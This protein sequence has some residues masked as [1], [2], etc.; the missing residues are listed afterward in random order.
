MYEEQVLLG[1]LVFW[2][3]AVYMLGRVEPYSI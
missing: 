1:V 3:M 2:L